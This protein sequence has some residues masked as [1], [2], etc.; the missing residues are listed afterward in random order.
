MTLPAHFY[1]A[2]SSASRWIPCPGSLKASADIPDEAGH[3]ANVGTLGHAMVEA[4]AFYGCKLTAD[5]EAFYDSLDEDTLN[6][7][8]YAVE[9]CVATIADTDADKVYHEAK[10]QHATIPQHGGT[11]DLIEYWSDRTLQ[12]TDYKFGRVKVDIEDNKQIQCYINLARQIF[13]D[14]DRFI[15]RIIQP[16]I[17]E[18]PQVA[19]FHAQQLAAHEAAVQAAWEHPDVFR[20]G[21]HCIYCPAAPQCETLACHLR[22]QV[23]NE[24]TDLTVLAGS[25]QDK[26]TAEQVEKLA[27]IYKAFKLAEK[28][29]EGAGAILKRWAQEGADVKK[30]GLGLRQ[31][32]RTYWADRA[33]DVLIAQGVKS[34][35]YLKDPDLVSPGDLRKALGLKK[36]DFEA[37]FRDALKVKAITALVMGKDQNEFPEFENLD[38]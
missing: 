5:Q 25:V 31:T 13:P 11:V 9:V 2:P 22:D 23:Q 33:E 37:K 36:A 32:S 10:I 8:D 34:K 24:F 6:F 28:A 26:P 12:V 38:G 4:Q 27:R 29:T 21:D 20:A 18:K 14:A 19:V 7:L 17:S 30:Y 3:A 35:D 16:R 15:G 1:L